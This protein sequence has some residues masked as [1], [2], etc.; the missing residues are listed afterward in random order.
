MRSWGTSRREVSLDTEGLWPHGASGLEAKGVTVF[1]STLPQ[2]PGHCLCLRGWRRHS[3]KFGSR[4]RV[5][6]LSQS[7]EGTHWV[8]GESVCYVTEIYLQK[9]QAQNLSTTDVMCWS[10]Y[11][12]LFLEGLHILYSRGSLKTE[13]K[14]SLQKLLRLWN[15]LWNLE[16]CCPSCYKFLMVWF[17]LYKRNRWPTGRTNRLIWLSNAIVSSNSRGPP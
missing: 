8:W 11:I 6:P 12:R 17:I 1:A 3:N 2:N 16:H 13:L 15:Q 5:S 9:E 10:S 7:A 14:R 4:L